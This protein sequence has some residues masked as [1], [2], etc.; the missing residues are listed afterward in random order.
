MNEQLRDFTEEETDDFL[1]RF[2]AYGGPEPS[3]R[4][5]RGYGDEWVLSKEDSKAPRIAA[6]P[7]VWRDPATIPRRQWVYGH[8]L[9]R[10]FLSTTVAPGAVG[11]SSLTMVEAIAMATGRALLGTPPDRQAPGVD[12]ERRGSA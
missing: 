2:G 7:F 9:I 8:H 10:R 12:L 1:R 4:W 3:S 6:K 11:K 5:E